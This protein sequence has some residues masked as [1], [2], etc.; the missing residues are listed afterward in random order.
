M[1]H[2]PAL[3]LIAGQKRTPEHVD[4]ERSTNHHTKEEEQNNAEPHVLPS[5]VHIGENRIHRNLLTGDIRVHKVRLI[6]TILPGGVL[7]EERSTF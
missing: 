4:C 1:N 3:I 5:Y 7:I 6:C 2:L